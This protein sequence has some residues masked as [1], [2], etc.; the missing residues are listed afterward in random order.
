[1]KRRGV[2]CEEV[3]LATPT[4]H[5]NK[6]RSLWCH[7]IYGLGGDGGG[8]QGEGR[9]ECVCSASHDSS[10]FCLTERSKPQNNDVCHFLLSPVFL[11]LLIKGGVIG[12][13]RFYAFYLLPL[14]S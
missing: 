13:G 8:G 12:D 7:Y 3:R 1:M 6:L 2:Y 5:T 10:R 14:F 9:G 4:L 11:K